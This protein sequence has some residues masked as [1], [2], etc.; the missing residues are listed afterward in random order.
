M[1][2]IAAQSWTDHTGALRPLLT[3]AETDMLCIARGTLNNEERQRINQH[4]DVTLQMLEVMPFPKT[5]ARV[6]EYAGG[7]HEKIDG[8]GFPRG[9]TGEQMSWPARMMA[10]AD[11]FEALTARDRPYKPPMPLSQA[12]S[13]LRDMRD[14]RHIDADLYA[15]FLEARVWETYAR[16]HLLP[17]QL[18]VQDPAAYR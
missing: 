18:D 15:L 12:L 9:L 11:I 5:L 1:R 8:T 14:R 6:P 2:D 7:H 10:I 17:D 16:E 3:P 13:I 4:I